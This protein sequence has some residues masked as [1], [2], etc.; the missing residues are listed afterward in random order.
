MYYKIHW[1]NII[2]DSSLCSFIVVLQYILF[3]GNALNNGLVNNLKYMKDNFIEI[4]KFIV[5]TIK[6]YVFV[7]ILKL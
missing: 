7:I 1:K 4:W 2:G 6:T 5:V 3:N